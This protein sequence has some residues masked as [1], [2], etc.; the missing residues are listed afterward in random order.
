MLNTW[1][2][3]RL[4]ATTLAR[5]R[6]PDNGTISVPKKQ[7]SQRDKIAIII[8]DE[9]DR[10]NNYQERGLVPKITKVNQKSKL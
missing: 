3:L 10:R 1:D 9:I 5:E 6:K 8:Q 4:R 7:L 2:T